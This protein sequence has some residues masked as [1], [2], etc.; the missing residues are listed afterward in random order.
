MLWVIT[1]PGSMLSATSWLH[2]RCVT[3]LDLGHS[4]WLD[5]LLWTCNDAIERIHTDPGNQVK[6]AADA[7]LLQLH[8]GLACTQRS[9]HHQLTKISHS[10]NAMHALNFHVIPYRL[11]GVP[12]LCRLWQTGHDLISRCVLASSLD[13]HCSMV[14]LSRTWPRLLLMS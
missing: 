8:A 12:V 3:D 2:S 7:A 6:Q 13:Q 5:A 11:V 14:F 1:T 9:H 4:W 10:I